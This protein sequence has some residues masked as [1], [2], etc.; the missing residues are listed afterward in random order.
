MEQGL[1]DVKRA[2][3]ASLEAKSRVAVAKAA[4]VDLIGDS[5]ES[6]SS[7]LV[8]E[9]DCMKKL[10]A[11]LVLAQRSADMTRR[12]LLSFCRQDLPLN[13]EAGCSSSRPIMRYIISGQAGAIPIDPGGIVCVED[14]LSHLESI[15]YEDDDAT[16]RRRVTMDYRLMHF[17]AVQCWVPSRA[18][19]YASNNLIT[20]KKRRL[21]D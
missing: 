2:K 1:A 17:G 9:I 8:E 20:S 16:A 10:K 21:K 19:L 14:L 13:P 7:W 6:L 15:S 12:E 4:L 3:S 11:D 18:T 5:E